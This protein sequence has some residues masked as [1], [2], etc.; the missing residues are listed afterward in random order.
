MIKFLS[1]TFQ[2]ERGQYSSNRF[3][4]IMCA[5]TLC[6]TL[7]HVQFVPQSTCPSSSL[8]DAITTLAFGSLGLGAANKIF[9]KTDPIK[10]EKPQ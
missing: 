9:K 6:V 7:Y 8:I 2:D 10:E 1:Q 3:V 5:I 4:G